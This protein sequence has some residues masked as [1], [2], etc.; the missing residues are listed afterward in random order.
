MLIFNFLSQMNAL[1]Y[2]SKDTVK[3]P[4]YLWFIRY[5][6]IDVATVKP[7]LMFV[8]INANPVNKINIY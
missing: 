4:N 2:N 5:N 3:I 6:F 1:Y 8:N 7:W